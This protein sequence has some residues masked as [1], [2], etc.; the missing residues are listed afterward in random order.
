MEQNV[1]GQMRMLEVGWAVTH[2]LIG[3]VM[4][5]IG[6]AGLVAARFGVWNAVVIGGGW[7]M[8]GATIYEGITGT[9][10]ELTLSKQ[11]MWGLL[12]FAFL[13]SATAAI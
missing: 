12:G 13:C 10:G 3:A 5:L 7:V 8:I 9:L 11:W 1:D 4:I 2:T 6:I